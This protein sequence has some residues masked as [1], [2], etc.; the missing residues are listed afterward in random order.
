GF[1]EAAW[2]FRALF[3]KTIW[4]LWGIGVLNACDNL[5]GF[6]GY[7]FGGGL[8]DKIGH[9]RVIILYEALNGFFYIIAI[10]LKNIFSPI[11]MVLPAF[12]WSA[13]SLSQEAIFQKEYS[14]EERATMGSFISFY[15]SVVYSAASILIGFC[16]DLYG[17]AMGLLFAA[18]MQLF[19]IP[20]YIKSFQKF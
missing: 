13:K 20:L 5:L 15:T 2:Q 11:L 16:A 12:F 9:K 8:I 14:D 6:V 3:I 18:L 7:R 19:A 10:L 4:P 1:S 17:I